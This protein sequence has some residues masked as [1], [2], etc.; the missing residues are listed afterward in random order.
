MHLKSY[1]SFSDCKNKNVLCVYYVFLYCLE[2]VQ[3]YKFCIN[4][5][6]Y[7]QNLNYIYFYRKIHIF[8]SPQLDFTR[9][10]IF[11]VAQHFPLRFCLKVIKHRCHFVKRHHTT[12]ITGLFLQLLTRTIADAIMENTNGKIFKAKFDKLKTQTDAIGRARAFNTQDNRV[13]L[14]LIVG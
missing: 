7:F 9:H 13:G 10:I 11:R 12:G 1:G 6:L 3:T 8:N 5:I 14:E 4:D 2:S